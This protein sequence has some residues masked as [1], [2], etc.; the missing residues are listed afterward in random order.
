MVA[1]ILG[2]K[3]GWAYRVYES[4]KIKGVPRY[5]ASQYSKGKR[6]ASNISMDDKEKVA[7]LFCLNI[8]A[9]QCL[10]DFGE[11]HHADS[12]TEIME[13]IKMNYGAMASR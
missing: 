9:F 11:H 12:I 6:I 10:E 3:K 7:K 2:Y 8:R 1:K 4:R 13:D 5:K